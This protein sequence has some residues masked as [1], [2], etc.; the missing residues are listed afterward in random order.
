[1]L[2]QL[3]ATVAILS[4]SIFAMPASAADVDIQINNSTWD[5]DQIGIAGALAVA[6]DPVASA[7]VSNIAG[8]ASVEAN[9]IDDVTA[10]VAVS[11]I[12]QLG[13]AAAVAWDWDGVATSEVTQV[14]GLVNVDA[15]GLTG[16]SDVLSQNTTN[17]VVQLGGSL[18]IGGNKAVASV[19]QLAGVT[20]MN[21]D[22]VPS[23]ADIGN[24]GL[25]V[26]AIDQVG[27]SVAGA[28]DIARASVSNLAGVGVV[29]VN[30]AD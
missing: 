20:V 26:N 25:Q 23:G 6:G 10:N 1:M 27:V 29:S 15:N 5:V 4:L 16:H 3:F 12:G 18:A 14:A 22:G 19:N 9:D 21:L 7:D 2:K 17:S 13:I 11:D 8:M 30:V 24:I 28:G